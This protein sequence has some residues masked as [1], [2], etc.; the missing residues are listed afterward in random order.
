MTNTQQTQS[1]VE[2][3]TNA[4]GEEKRYGIYYPERAQMCRQLQELLRLQATKELDRFEFGE[5]RA[6][7]LLAEYRS[8]FDWE[9]KYSVEVDWEMF[10]YSHT[11][12]Y[13]CAAKEDALSYLSGE[14]E[15]EQP[16]LGDVCPEYEWTG[17]RSRPS[18]KVQVNNLHPRKKHCGVS[19][20]SML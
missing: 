9:E 15:Y 5:E 4:K 6:I 20:Q 8:N 14:K 2:E 10:I 16:D 18:L 3:Y 19:M 17:D 7:E 11:E 12:E 13:E 1:L